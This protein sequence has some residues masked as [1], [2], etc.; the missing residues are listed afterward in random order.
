M[1]RK[2]LSFMNNTGITSSE[3]ALS[4]S[5]LAERVHIDS[6]T[7]QRLLEVLY[8]RGLI[9]RTATKSEGRYYLSGR[10]VLAS[11]SGLS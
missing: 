2:L 8:S 6:G 10:G 4:A 7:A 9:L 5:T 1:S 3:R 11:V